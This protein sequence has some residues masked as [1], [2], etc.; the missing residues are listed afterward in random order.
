MLSDS[1][2]ID[3]Q[4]NFVEDAVNQ[5]RLRCDNGA[6]RSVCDECQWTVITQ[7]DQRAVTGEQG[8][9]QIESVECIE[10]GAQF[11]SGQVIARGVCSASI[12]V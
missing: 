4:G 8:G 10:V 3:A 7:M 11:F 2:F 1:L 6:I 12:E 5:A 9:I